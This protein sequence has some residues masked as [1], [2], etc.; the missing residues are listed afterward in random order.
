M[1][2][3]FTRAGFC[4]SDRAGGPQRVGGGELVWGEGRSAR[5]PVPLP[6]CI[7]STQGPAD[8]QVGPQGDT[9]AC[10]SAAMEPVGLGVPP[11]SSPLDPSLRKRALY[12]L[13]LQHPHPH[14][15]AL[16]CLLPQV[17][18]LVQNLSSRL[19]VLTALPDLIAPS[20]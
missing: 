20:S 7:L 18:Y 8:G 19:P 2:F 5:V 3:A 14:L 13:Y 4:G 6:W 17:P 11:S 15:L 9:E 1:C 16:W 10:E 12:Q